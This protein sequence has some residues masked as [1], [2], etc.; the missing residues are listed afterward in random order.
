MIAHVI[1]FSLSFVGIWIGSGL[2]IKSVERISRTF[3]ISQ[4]A[5]SFIVLGFFTSISELSVGINSILEN[6]PEIF[7]GN[8][9]GGSIVIFM[10]LI[11]LLAI[12]GKPIKISLEFQGF[13]LTASLLVVGLPVILVMD[14]VIGK[15]DSVLTIGFYAFLLAL[16]QTKRSLLERISNINHRSGIIIGRELLKIL[17]G[18][19]TIFIA[20][21]FV[22]EQTMYF[23]QI[24]NVSPF[25]ISLLMIALGTNIPELSLV[26][27]S[28]FMKNNQVAFGDYIGSAAFN[29]FLLGLL[30]LVY[31]KPIQL[32]NSYLTSLL[33]SITGLMLFYFFSRTKNSVNRIEGMVL[34][35]LYALFILTEI[36][37]HRN[38]LFWLNG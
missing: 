2:A 38:L 36:F 15:L 27:R 12:V 23:S 6:D 26:I 5:I 3:K 34:L 7:V 25:L 17:F 18:V 4:F 14:G 37:L 31:D 20:S 32:N 33:F 1:L 29:T 28:I 10:L 30:S 11:P 8:L 13:N 19:T 22:V 24:I 35:S 16:T 21:K 9:I